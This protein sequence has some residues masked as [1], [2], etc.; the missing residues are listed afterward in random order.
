MANTL[1]MQV[2]YNKNTLAYTFTYCQA[3]NLIIDNDYLAQDYK[4]PDYGNSSLVSSEPVVKHKV[5]CSKQKSRRGRRKK[6]QPMACQFCAKVG[7]SL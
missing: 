3:F 1:Q 7:N 5:S 4:E 6:R 2:D